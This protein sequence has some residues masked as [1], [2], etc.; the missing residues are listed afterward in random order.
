MRKTQQNLSGYQENGQS[1]P[2]DNQFIKDFNK[3]T[4]INSPSSY[5]NRLGKWRSILDEEYGVGE[6]AKDLEQSED[7]DVIKTWVKELDKL[8]SDKYKS[9]EQIEH[10]TNLIQS[11]VVSRKVGPD[12]PVIGPF[13]ISNN[14]A[15]LPINSIGTEKWKDGVLIDPQGWLNYLVTFTP[16]E[17]VI[18]SEREVAKAIISTAADFDEG[19]SLDEYLDL[20]I[21]KSS[22]ST[23]RD[24]LKEIILEAP[25]ATELKN[26][27]RRGDGRAVEETG[28][29]I[30]SGLEEYIK[31]ERETTEKL[32]KASRKLNEEQKEKE[33]EREREA[34][35]I[36][37]NS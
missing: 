3:R 11:V 2:F 33:K 13:G 17:F 4:D 31:R 36:R 23:E 7:Y 8:K 27:A 20:L 14:T 15:L 1:D 12:G 21:A 35:A 10:D 34:E 6:Y 18:G 16:A 9:P 28:Y 5:S 26:A 24:Y 37:E 19:Y 29:K 25:L 30:I 22:M 32:R